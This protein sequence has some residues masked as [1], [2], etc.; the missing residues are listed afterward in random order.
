MDPRERSR[1]LNLSRVAAAAV[2]L[3]VVVVMALRT[4]SAKRDFV[5]SFEHFRASRLWWVV[6]AAGSELVALAAYGMQQRRL[7]LATGHSITRRS[8]FALALGATGISALVPIGVVPA[9]GWLISQYRL[10]SIGWQAALWTVLAGGFVATVTILALLLVGSAV[11]GIG[12][13]VL[14]AGSGLVLVSGSGAFV[15]AVHRLRRLQEAAASHNL[16][17]SFALLRRAAGSVGSIS[18]LRAGWR[19]G[20]EAFGWSALNWLADAACLLCSFG[21][22]GSPLPWH[23]ILFA[24][25]A[26]QLAG[27][28][29]PLPAGIGVVEGGLVGAFALAGLPSGKVLAATVVYR[30][31]GY[32]GVAGAGGM[33]VFFMSHHIA[34]RTG[35]SGSAQEGEEAQLCVVAQ[36]GQD[37]SP[38]ATL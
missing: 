31:I 12:P 25:A 22:I 24:F 19:G 9:S 14:L 36:A 17:R 26:A 18:C 3:L 35:R 7:L 8:A 38:A 21:L 2:V 5:R 11:A 28:I 29:S 4:N 37:S 33:S 16:R 20:T 15:A 27:S 13:P 23:A 32:W 30:V 1:L 6:A 10:R 34:P